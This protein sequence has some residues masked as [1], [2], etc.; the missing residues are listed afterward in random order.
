[1]IQFRAQQGKASLKK[2]NIIS[3]LILMD[4]IIKSLGF[5]GLRAYTGLKDEYEIV[6][7]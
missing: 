5:L 1:M 7:E 4:R 2:G 6:G 3:P